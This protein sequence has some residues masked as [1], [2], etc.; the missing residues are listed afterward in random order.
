MW[1]LDV[2][3]DSLVFVPLRL[4]RV[5]GG[6]QGGAGVQLADDARLG[7]AERLLLHH[8]VQHAPGRLGHLVELIDAANA[9]VGQH[10]GAA[11]EWSEAVT[12][13]RGT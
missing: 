5:G 10:E 2:L 3:D 13:S 7:D 4:A 8:L 9:V 12:N 11:G 6:Q 1:Q